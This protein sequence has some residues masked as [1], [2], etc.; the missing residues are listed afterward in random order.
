M[1]TID[2]FQYVRAGLRGLVA[3]VSLGVSAI[4][5][6]PDGRVILVK[7]TYRSGWY[8]P[9]GGVTRGETGEAAVMRELAEETG[10][11]RSAAPALF[12][13]Y[14]RR[15]GGHSDYIALYQVRDAVIAFRPNTEI[16]ALTLADAAAPP[17]GTSAGTLRR[18][19]EF[20]GG[21]ARSA[22]W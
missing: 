15:N 11:V 1:K 8:L 19:A 21:T 17:D 12:G 18:L 14:L 10:L 22:E 9:G 5:T 2:R 7:H 6:T 4:A 16:A 3:P 13:F 20:A